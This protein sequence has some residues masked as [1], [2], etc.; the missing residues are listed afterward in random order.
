MLKITF[1]NH[2]ISKFSREYVPPSSS[3]VRAFGARN[4]CLTFH[5]SLATALSPSYCNWAK[6][7]EIAYVIDGGDLSGRN[8]ASTFLLIITSRNDNVDEIKLIIGAISWY[9]G[10]K[11]ARL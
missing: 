3:E 4:T 2:S 5:E 6:L 9:D 10:L 7:Q 1:Q 11:H 8:F